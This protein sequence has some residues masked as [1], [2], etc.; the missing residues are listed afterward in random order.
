MQTGRRPSKHS[1]MPANSVSAHR[2]SLA[3]RVGRV[4]IPNPSVQDVWFGMRPIRFGAPC[5]QNNYCQNSLF[6]SNIKILLAH[7]EPKLKRAHL[8]Q[9][10]LAVH[11]LLSINCSMLVGLS[12]LARLVKLNVKRFVPTLFNWIQIYLWIH[13]KH[14]VYDSITRICGLA[15]W[16]NNSLDWKESPLTADFGSCQ[17]NAIEYLS[18][19]PL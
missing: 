3:L 14:F 11:Q 2:F 9:K 13:F 15:R 17:T 6:M 19:R 1:R 8:N 4:L 18:L 16:D 7:V 10:V 5:D 12:W